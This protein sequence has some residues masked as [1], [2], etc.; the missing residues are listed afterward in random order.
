MRPQLIK[1]NYL[2][3]QLLNG[4]NLNVYINIICL[5]LI[6]I[7]LIYLTYRYHNKDEYKKHKLE[8]KKQNMKKIAELLNV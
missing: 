6:I 4:R 1:Y 8:N 5:S 7:L 2:P 3:K